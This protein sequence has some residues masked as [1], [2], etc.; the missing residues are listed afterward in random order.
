MQRRA[1]KANIAAT[2]QAEIQ[3]LRLSNAKLEGTKA[4]MEFISSL[5]EEKA[6]QEANIAVLKQ[7]VDAMGQFGDTSLLT[8]DQ[9]QNLAE[10]AAGVPSAIRALAGEIGG[11]AQ[12][13][14]KFLEFAGEEDE[15]IWKLEDC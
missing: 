8:A 3:S 12:E 10:V 11:L 9:L 15:L 7:S 4:A 1:L 2:R 5:D 6:S 13:A 14:T